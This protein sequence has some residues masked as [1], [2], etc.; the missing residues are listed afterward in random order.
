MVNILIPACGGTDFFE[1]CFYPKNLYE[2]KGQP[3]IQRV[4]ENYSTV[5][6]AKFIVVLLQEE[7]NKF[8]TDNVVSLIADEF[9]EVIRLKSLTC[10]GLCSCLMGIEYIN[11]DNELIISNNDQLID[12]NF[13]DVLSEFR[14]ENA[15]C[16]VICFKAVHPRWSYIKTD[17]VSVIETAEKRPIAHQ[18]IAGFY[19]FKKGTEFVEAAKRAIRKGSTCNGKYYI[20]AALNEMILMNKDIR[21]YNIKNEAYHS[22]YMPERIRQYENGENL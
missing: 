17:G 18:A 1:D 19:Y 7:C 2:I 5:H 13:E 22:F 14:K 4:V 9:T 20:T 12:I 6:N 21:V 10:G 11:N 15:D 8:H 16:G 3:M